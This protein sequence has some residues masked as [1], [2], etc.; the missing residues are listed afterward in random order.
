MCEYTPPYTPQDITGAFE[1]S[2]V[3]IGA[4]TWT[5]QFTLNVSD[6]AL[7]PSTVQTWDHFT[8]ISA[9]TNQKTITL[10]LRQFDDQRLDVECTNYEVTIPRHAL[11]TTNGDT[12]AN[13]IS[14]N[15]EVVG[16]DKTTDPQD[17]NPQNQD[18]EN[19]P[20][21][22]NTIKQDNFYLSLYDTDEK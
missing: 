21:Y 20:K 7:D 1:K 5:L 18:E 4:T 22:E 3:S 2:Q 15:F 17:S 9:T 19:K 16:C 10:T 8:A 11:T 13:P 6:A 12:N 14:G